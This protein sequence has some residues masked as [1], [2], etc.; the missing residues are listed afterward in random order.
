MTATTGKLADPEFR[1]ERASNAARASHSLAAHVRA[2]V[3]GAAELS[4][5]EREQLALAAE[6]KREDDDG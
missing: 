3:A 2:V 4:D 6:R 5:D 1:R